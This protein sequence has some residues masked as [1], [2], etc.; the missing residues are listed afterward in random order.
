M[1]CQRT[2]ASGPN[3]D[4]ILR[5]IATA[6]EPLSLLQST[7]SS[8]AQKLGKPSRKHHVALEDNDPDVLTLKELE[9]NRRLAD[10]AQ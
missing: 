6:S 7:I 4:Y 3:D 5:A 9:R 8:T 1:S 10:D 2:V